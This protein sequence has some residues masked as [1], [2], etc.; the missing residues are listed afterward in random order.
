MVA[1][2]QSITL[3]L[4]RA[5]G[6]VAPRQ[7]EV[8]RSIARCYAVFG[9]P[10]VPCQEDIR[11]VQEAVVAQATRKRRGGFS[12]LILGVTP[13]IAAMNWPADTTITAV[14]MS[15]AVIDALWP[16]D[17]AGVRQALCASWLAI[18]GR[19]SCYNAA[20]GDGA[21]NVVRF[22]DLPK[23]IRSVRNA[24]VDSGTFTV[25]SYIRPHE[26]ESVEAVF[27]AL[28][29]PSG[30]NVDSFKMRF[31]LAM[32]R[33]TE[34]GVAV[35]EAFRL[36][37]RYGIDHNVMRGRLGWN[38]AAIEPFLRWPTS[39]S[40]YTFPTLEE[41]RA[42]LNECFEEVSI[43]YPGY[44]LGHSCPTLVLRSR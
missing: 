18:P 11:I 26:S 44:E 5:A 9:S 14:D 37:E 1:S 36:L 12:A 8:W 35:R 6:G 3:A 30:L 7:D 25:R 21:L 22:A 43:T 31:Y 29:G 41:L 13:A 33:S 38:S 24:L 2:P 20:V 27:D 4:P 10:F 23:L 17:I 34:E 19:Q 42:A 32:Q 28:V 15:Q 16:G 40:V 39:D